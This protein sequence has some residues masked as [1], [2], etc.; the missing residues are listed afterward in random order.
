MTARF[1]FEQ[2][3]GATPG[4]AEQGKARPLLDDLE[5]KAAP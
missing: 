4:D 2:A 5:A 3:I 1:A